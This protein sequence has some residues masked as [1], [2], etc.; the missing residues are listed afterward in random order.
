MKNY[1]LIKKI[2][3][4]LSPLFFNLNIQNNNQHRKRKTLDKNQYVWMRI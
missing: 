1:F 2:N 3:K 4:I